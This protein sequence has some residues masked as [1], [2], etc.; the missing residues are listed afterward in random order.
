MTAL[1]VE[2]DGVTA[3][4]AP[5][6]TVLDAARAAGVGIPT[7]CFDDRQD[8]FGACRV[9]MVGVQGA[10]AASICFSSL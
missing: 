9:C 8:P 10:P 7:L 5:G 2:I 1:R 6:T 3:E 4:V